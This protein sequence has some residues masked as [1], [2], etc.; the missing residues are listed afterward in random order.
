MHIIT[1]SFD[2]GFLQSNLKIAEIYEKYNLSACFNVI[3]TQPIADKGSPKGDFKLWNELQGR[4]HEIMPHGYQHVNKAKLPLQQAQN[5]IVDCLDIF[6]AELEGFAAQRAIF[7]FPYNASTPELETW[8]TK[9]VGVFRTAGS[10]IN[11]LPH[12]GM[13]RLTTTAFGPGNC[14]IHLDRQIE[15][16]LSTPSGWLIYNLHGLD[17]EGWGPIRA[18][19]LD[20]LLAKLTQMKS[21]LILPAGKA[22]MDT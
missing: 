10:G 1:L 5:L 7:N 13:Q 8:L 9:K 18:S 15:K 14:E 17:N 12:S 2:D 21:V 11:P 22:L 4:G 20:N 3:A 6:T 19:Y 16:L